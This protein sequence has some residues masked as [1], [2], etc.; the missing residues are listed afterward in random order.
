MSKI[1]FNDLVDIFGSIANIARYCGI[2]QPSVCGWRD[3]KSIPESRLIMMAPYIESKTIN[4]ERPF[5]RKM[6]FPDKWHVIWP[7]LADVDKAVNE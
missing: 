1:T 3:N 6:L 4:S 5:T 2:R 7:E